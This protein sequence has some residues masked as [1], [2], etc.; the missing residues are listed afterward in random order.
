VPFHVV[1][2]SLTTSSE[3]WF[4]SGDVLDPILASAALPGLFPPVVIDGDVL[5]D[6][7]VLNNVP[8]SKAHEL[9]PNRIFVFHVGNFDRTRPAPKRPIDVLLH[10]FSI[11]RSYRFES[12]AKQA[13]TPGVE[14]VSLPSADPGKLRYYDF[15]HSAELI[16]RGRA[17]TAAFLDNATVAASQSG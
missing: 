3:R 10:A 12:E 4:C 5:V 17:A 15:R 7:G 11:S 13:A 14:I 16:E 6:G 9:R 8:V 1:A 2:T